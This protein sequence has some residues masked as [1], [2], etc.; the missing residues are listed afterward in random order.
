MSN[1]NNINNVKQ[2]I[3]NTAFRTQPTFPGVTTP[4]TQPTFPTDNTKNSYIMTTDSCP[5]KLL[6]RNSQSCQMH[7]FSENSNDN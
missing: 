5:F 4:K 7:N 1:E 3:K 6:K 2:P